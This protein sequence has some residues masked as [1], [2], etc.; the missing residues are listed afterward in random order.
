MDT[1]DVPEG[2]ARRGEGGLSIPQGNCRKAVDCLSTP[3]SVGERT[4]REREME[5]E[6]EELGGSRE[7]GTG[8]DG[9]GQD[10]GHVLDPGSRLVE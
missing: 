6:R 7:R 1:A 10:M 2:G 5:G 8:T 9:Q 4:E 3:A